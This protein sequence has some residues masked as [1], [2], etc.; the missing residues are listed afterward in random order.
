MYIFNEE[1]LLRR[2]PK[3]ANFVENR[4]SIFLDRIHETPGI[5][6]SSIRTELKEYHIAA[7]QV[8]ADWRETSR[9]NLSQLL[10]FVQDQGSSVQLQ[11]L[12]VGVVPGC[13][14]CQ[15]IFQINLTCPTA[16]SRI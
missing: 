16:P 2:P 5:G 8:Y 12:G 1:A 15:N 4:V 11:K 3:I 7:V 9:I 13:G 10:V 6:T 14:R